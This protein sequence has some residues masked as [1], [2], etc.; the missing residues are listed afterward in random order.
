MDYFRQRSFVITD[1]SGLAAFE[2]LHAFVCL[3]KQDHSLDFNLMQRRN[4]Q[5]RSVLLIRTL[6]QS[7]AVSF[8]NLPVIVQHRNN[9]P[10]RHE[11]V[12]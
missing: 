12:I 9:Y 1:F 5:F 8:R 3:T 6:W 7:L 4:L 11:F 2:F 10:E